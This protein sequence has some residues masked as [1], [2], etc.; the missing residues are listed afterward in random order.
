MQTNGTLFNI[1]QC[2]RVARPHRST[3]EVHSNS[4]LAPKTVRGSP[5]FT[6]STL[7]M[8]G[9]A[10]KKAAILGPPP[11]FIEYDSILLLENFFHARRDRLEDLVR[12]LA[13]E[14]G[15]R[16]RLW[17]VPGDFLQINTGG[18]KYRL[19]IFGNGAVDETGG[20]IHENS[21]PLHANQCA[22]R[23]NCLGQI[24]MLEART[25]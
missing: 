3:I 25:G 23:E 17:L 1:F 2:I 11:C 10:A 21:G 18:D 22:V 12:H 5:F 19:H 9:R 20:G 13:L 14:L 7:I 4:S 16:Q 8:P 24:G 15:R 6:V